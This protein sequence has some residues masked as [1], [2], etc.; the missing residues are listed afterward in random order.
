MN[1]PG[2]QLFINVCSL[3]IGLIVLQVVLKAWDRNAKAKA[4]EAAE[5]AKVTKASAK[6]K[7]K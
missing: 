7:K 6:P 1:N 4:A 2:I 5:A 3:L